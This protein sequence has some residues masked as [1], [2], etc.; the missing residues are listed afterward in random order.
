[1]TFWDELFNRGFPPHQVYQ[2]QMLCQLSGKGEDEI[3]RWFLLFETSHRDRGNLCLS[4][5]PKDLKDALDQWDWPVE[6]S[7]KQLNQLKE[8]LLSQGPIS[9]NQALT[10]YQGENPPYILHHQRLYSRRHFNRE[11]SLKELLAQRLEQTPQGLPQLDL[12]GVEK[13]MEAWKKTAPF[14]PGEELLQA[15]KRLCSQGLSIISGGPGTGKTTLLLSLVGLLQLAAEVSGQT[16]ARITLAA[17]TGRAAKRMSETLAILGDQALEA[18]TL[19]RLLG[20]NSSRPKTLNCG[21]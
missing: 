4:L 9:F 2:A 11:T 13:L 18:Q 12:S 10:L 3:L 1:M 17:P 8:T 6:S 21:G 20:L 19:H 5:T 7:Q 16:M 14:P 15:F